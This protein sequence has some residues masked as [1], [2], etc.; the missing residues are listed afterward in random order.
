MHAAPEVQTQVHGRRTQ[1]GQPCRCAGQQVECHHVGRISRIGIQGAI[2]GV[3]RLDLVVRGFKAR[4]YRI[5]LELDHRGRNALLCQHL[6]HASGRGAIHAHRRLGRRD[7][8]RWRLTKQVGQRV[9]QA[10]QQRDKNDRVLPQ[11]VTVHV[12][13]RPKRPSSRTT[14]CRL[15]NCPAQVRQRENRTHESDGSQTALSEPLGSTCTTAERC[16]WTSTPSVSST[17]M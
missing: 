6:F 8:H 17:P 15:R 14:G 3:A 9:D 7:L 2:D 5:A 16:I 10:D 1:T 4:A 12:E 13:N 11:R